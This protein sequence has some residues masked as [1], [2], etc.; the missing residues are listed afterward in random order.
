MAAR[1]PDD[2]E[3][4][5]AGREDHHRAAS[6]PEDIVE[7]GFRS[8]LDPGGQEMKVMVGMR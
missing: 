6:G 5:A 7:K 3:R 4:Q 1:H 2:L 8:L